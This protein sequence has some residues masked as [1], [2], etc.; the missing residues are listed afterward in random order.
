MPEKIFWLPKS[1]KFKAG[2]V[3]AMIEASSA[4]A[5]LATSA[6][7]ISRA[8]EQPPILYLMIA[9]VGVRAFALARA[10][11]RYVQRLLLHDS[12]FT[13][14]AAL[15]P[16]I[17]RQIA[18]A[19]PSPQVSKKSL[20]LERLTNDVDELQNFVLRVLTPI[21]Q[22]ATA[23]A[24][25]SLILAISFPI[26]AALVLL[27]SVATL[28]AVYLVTH[29][30]SAR[31]EARS[32]DL[33]ASLRHELLEY[34]EFAQ[35]LNHYE[36]DQARKTAIEGLSQELRKN[37]GRLAVAQGLAV[38]LVGLLATISVVI[39]SLL[40]PGYL[41]AGVAGNLL[42][43]AVL[44]PL[45]AFDLIAGVQGAAAAMVR[46][47][48]ARSRLEKI[49]AAGAGLEYSMESGS[50]ELVSLKSI[51]LKNLGLSLGDQAILNQANLILHPGQMVAITGFSGSGK[52]SLAQTIASLRNPS[53]GQLLFNESNSATYSLT[54]R[55]R[56]VMLVEQYPHIFAGTVSDNLGISGIEDNDAQIQALIQVGLWDEI[57]ERGGLEM[58][59]SET[60]A[61]IS[62][63]QAQR[64]AI[65]RGLLAGSS[66][67]ILDEPT[68]GL[69][70]DNSS[71][72][73]ELLRTL[74]AAGKLILVVTHDPQ[75][76]K[77]CDR[78]ISVSDWSR[79]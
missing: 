70:W 48:G 21:L 50:E 39:S 23:I 42:A 7:L 56:Q 2:L 18:A 53:S 24:V 75:I 57:V 64:L 11:G 3:V 58:Q 4:V 41:E 66:A 62:G 27:V 19:T 71:R 43:V 46:F 61:N 30:T 25:T 55:R 17:F 40:A 10:A 47:R 1:L 37:S 38:A 74:A 52:T 60:A 5:L 22:A 51:E 78:E 29:I 54:S 12:V 34:I 8:S 6:Y 76:A 65:A 15:R 20:N 31:S 32:V 67:L 16:M 13:E 72:L 35:V 63:G 36:M 33:R 49:A 28:I 14:S 77:L 69:D 73:I 9:V 68:S 79:K 44:V 59:I 26:V 45:A